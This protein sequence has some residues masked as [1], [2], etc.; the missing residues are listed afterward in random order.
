M[1]ITIQAHHVLLRNTRIVDIR[2]IFILRPRII[3]EENE[4]NVTML[5]TFF[6]HLP[7]Q[8]VRKHGHGGIIGHI[9]ALLIRISMAFPVL[10]LLFVFI[11]IDRQL[12][13]APERHRVGSGS[14]RNLSQA[15]IF[16]TIFAVGHHF[17]HIGIVQLSTIKKDALL[18]H[19]ESFVAF[20]SPR[21]VL[22]ESI[23]SL[24]IRDKKCFT[25]R[26]GHHIRVVQVVD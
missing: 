1:K 16:L 20:H 10:C 24:I 22:E 15:Q 23:I 9:Y 17:H 21:I 2:T 13:P 6:I 3:T 12:V 26:L 18:R 5:D 4:R 11:I 19:R 14:R 8:E 7:F 25:T